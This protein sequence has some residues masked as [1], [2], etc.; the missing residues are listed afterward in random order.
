MMVFGLLLA[1]VV[2]SS[3]VSAHGSVAVT[4]S[5]ANQWAG[6]DIH[7]SAWNQPTVQVEQEAIH[8]DATQVAAVITHANGV[9]TITADY[10]GPRTSSLFG[11]LK[12]GSGV[13]VRWIV[14]VPANMALSVVA[15]NGEISVDGVTA[16]LDARTSNGE[17]KIV[18]AG[19]IVTGRTSNGEVNVTIATLAGGAPNIDMRSSNGGLT[20]NVPKAFSTRVAARTSNGSIDNP[21]KGASGPGTAIMHTSNGDIDVVVNQ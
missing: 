10:R 16:A 12:K 18:G 15:A 19:P 9:T 8:G 1:A 13:S 20:L 4:T 21:F 6:I 17:V 14:H 7:V 2:G 11:L 5:E 3:P